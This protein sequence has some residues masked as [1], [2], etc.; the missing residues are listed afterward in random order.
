MRTRLVELTIVVN[1]TQAE[2][3]LRVGVESPLS[4]GRLRPFVTEVFQIRQ[5][6]AKTAAIPP[7][8]A[9]AQI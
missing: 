5:R 6:I 4:D 3:I 8:T 9:S 7:S 2:H 1:A